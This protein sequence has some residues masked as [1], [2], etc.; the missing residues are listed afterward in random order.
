[1]QRTILACAM[2]GL[3]ISATAIGQGND[4]R[5]KAADNYSFKSTLDVRTFSQVV[6]QASKTHLCGGAKAHCQNGPL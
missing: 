3:M 1:M 5:L 6:D 4:A 2:A